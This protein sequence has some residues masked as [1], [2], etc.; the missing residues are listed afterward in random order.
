MR[1][2]HLLLSLA[3][4]LVGSASAWADVEINETNFPDENFRLYLLDQEWGADFTITD[5]EIAEITSLAVNSKKIESLKGI[6]HFTALKSLVCNSNYNLTELD[7]TALTALETLNCSGC[8]LASLDVSRLQ[9]LKDLNCSSNSAIAELNVAQNTALTRLNCSSTSLTSLDVTK[10]TELDTLICN[11]LSKLTEA[12][13]LSNNKKLLYLSYNYGYAPV[14]PSKNTELQYLSLTRNTTYTQ[15]DLSGL[16]KLETLN[17][18]SCSALTDLNIDGCVALKSLNIASTKIATPDFSK[19][20]ALE[21]LT[22]GSAALQQLDVT[23]NSALKTLSVTNTGLTELDLS[24]NLLLETLTCS[25]NKLTGLDLSKNTALKSVTCKGNGLKGRSMTQ[26]IENLPT[27]ENGILVA[28]HFASET[29]VVNTTQVAA[30][31]AKGWTVKQTDMWGD[32][33]DEKGVATKDDIEINE[34]N[35][36]DEQLRAFLL[37]QEYGEDFKI[38]DDEIYDI[39]VL[40]MAYKGIADLTG[41]GNFTELKELNVSSNSKLTAID[42]SKNTKLNILNINYNN[43]IQTLDLTANNKL[44]SLSANSCTAL[45]Q[46]DLQKQMS[47]ETLNFTGSKAETLNLATCYSLKSLNLSNNRVITTIDLANNASLETLNLSSCTE[48]ATLD[49]TANTQLKS[50]NI[51]NTKISDL[52][53]AIL[54]KLES[55]TCGGTVSALTSLDLSQ[56]TALKSLSVTYSGLTSLDL[57]ALTALET[58]TVSNNKWE[59]LDLSKNTALKSIT[60]KTCGLKDEA[61]DNFISQLPTV[62]EGKLVAL[63]EN[64]ETNVMTTTQVEAAKA[65]GWTT[66]MTDVWGDMTEYKG[67][68][69]VGVASVKAAT[70]AAGAYYTIDGRQLP[71]EPVSKGIYVVK[72]R[73]MIRK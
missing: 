58:L 27:V 56:N 51:Y 13:D 71:A 61:M 57:S 43:Q 5:A 62:E 16:T 22:C 68:E 59:Q 50:L 55:L 35:F 19:L 53:M 54:T 14:D 9:A 41:I 18:S 31:K 52:N 20:S 64:A 8:K 63:H 48:M 7:V 46:L 67:S 33:V 1:T 25:S 73:K 40:N 69:P 12:F 26:L 38:S 66:Y 23:K 4:T 28:T 6:E 37:A 36:P 30:A 34:T 70:E 32:M 65:K 3:L 72:G 49:L 15:L 17:V 47:L 29:N 10:N 45:L 60:C 42:L 39:T 11:S 24:G 44:T 2:R 21:S